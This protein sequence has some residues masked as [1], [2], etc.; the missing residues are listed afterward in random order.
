[1]GALAV[2]DVAGVPAAVQDATP[3]AT[4]TA[5]EPSTTTLF[6][7]TF[8]QGS[9][10]PTEGDATTFVL[11]LQGD[12]GHTVA[13]SDRPERVV[14]AVPTQAFLDGLGFSPRNPPNAALVFEPSPGKTDFLVLKLLEPTYDVADRL[15]TYDVKPLDDFTTQMGLTFEQ[16]PRLPNPQ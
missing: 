7:Q 5:L 2:S 6:V 16:T 9:L 8:E 15:L 3:L 11:T 14:S 13:F 12:S 10:Q 4:P 1:V